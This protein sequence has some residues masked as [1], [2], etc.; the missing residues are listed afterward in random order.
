MR[1]FPLARTAARSGAP[2]HLAGSLCVALLDFWIP[3]GLTL[4][5]RVILASACPIS[6]CI[7]ASLFQSDILD[8]PACAHSLSAKSARCQLYASET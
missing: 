6:L 1:H 5:S 4:T 7:P 8:Y 2:L 3:M